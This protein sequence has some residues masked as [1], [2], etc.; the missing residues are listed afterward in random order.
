MNEAKK[1]KRIT[2]DNDKDEEKEKWRDKDKYI[3]TSNRNYISRSAL[4]QETTSVEIKGKCIIEEN[5]ILRGDLASI[6]MGRY[7]IIKKNTYLLPSELLI[8]EALLEEKGEKTTKTT[9]KTKT[10]NTKEGIHQKRTKIPMSIGNMTFIDSNCH[11]KAAYIG[12]NVHI[13]ENVEIG[14]RSVIKDNVIIEANTI[15]PPDAVIPPFAHVRGQPYRIVGEVS[16]AYPSIYPLQ[17]KQFY[18]KFF[19]CARYL[20]Y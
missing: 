2:K 9:K 17:R 12:C 5:V 16:P 3:E 8:E 19:Q 18:S 6:R 11:I 14:A 15:I 1:G 4:I 10:K 20:Y 7:C 13:G